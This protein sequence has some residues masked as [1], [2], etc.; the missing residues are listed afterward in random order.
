LK[1]AGAVLC[2]VALLAAS[3]CAVGPDYERPPQSVP[4]DWGPVLE[5]GTGPALADVAWFELFDDPQ[6][7]VLIDEALAANLELRGALARV[8]SAEARARGARAALLP[9][10]IGVLQSSPAPGLPD[11]TTHALGAALA[12]ELD[13]FGKLRRGREAA[14]ADLLGTEDGARA[15]LV[16]LVRNVAGAYFRVREL[17]RRVAILERTIDS[18][19]SSLALVRELKGSGIVS[20]AEENQ[21]LA[22][23][24]STRAVLPEL[25]AQRAIA[26]NALALLLARPPGHVLEPDFGQEAPDLPS[27]ATGL[28]VELLARR[29]DLRA[30][31]QRLHAATARVGVA[32][33]NRFPFPTI[34]VTALAGRL[35]T[36]L[37]D[38]LDEGDEVLS[39]GPTAAVPLLDFGRT[40][41]AVAFADAE[42]HAA[43]LAWRQAVLVALRE[44]ADAS[45]SLEAASEVIEHNRT[46]V[47]AAGD[48]LRLQKMRFRQG[49]VAFIEV[50][51]AE[52]Q[53][54]AAEQELV[55][56][57]YG[58]T[59][60]FL[61]LYRA[62]GGGADE[63]RLRQTL[64]SLRRDD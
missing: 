24:A 15:V 26:A 39:W 41:A 47:A 52:R 30:A 58:R 50:L 2:C 48:A 56:A 35:A 6:L 10:V 44:V 9:N 18:Q 4:E 62:L 7:V 64:A 27:F 21:A 14:L 22:L 37:G 32:V 63:E 28:P 29:P 61:E 25:R 40:G 51:D 59:Q 34:G 33:A 43:A 36:D 57:E 38:L 11:D 16:T 5:A 45:I 12:W 1:R 60:R 46:R 3:G 17:D 49:V 42:M 55:A 53:L 13:V 54:L 8:L 20:A 23:L 31:E 19:E